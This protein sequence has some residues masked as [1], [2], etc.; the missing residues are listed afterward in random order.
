MGIFDKVRG[1]LKSKE[2]KDEKPTSEV[3]KKEKN[4]FKEDF[5]K[6]VNYEKKSSLSPDTRNKLE[7]ELISDSKFDLESKLRN[8]KLG[9]GLEKT[10]QSFFW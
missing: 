10:K 1:L 2:I 7:T 8:E 5:N 6:E 4:D 9:L 3:E